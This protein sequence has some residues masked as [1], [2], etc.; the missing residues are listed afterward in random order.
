V[1]DIFDEIHEI[2]IAG[3]GPAGLTAAIY[4]ARANLQPGHG[5]GGGRGGA[6]G[7][8]H[9]CGELPGFPEGILGPDLIAMMKKQ[10]ER[11]GTRVLTDH[12]VSC[13]LSKRPFTVSLRTARHLKAQ[14][15]IVSTGASAS[16]LGLESE[17][18]LKGH[19][20]TACATCDG[21]FFKG[22]EV[23]VIGGGDTAMEEATFLTKFCSKVTVIH[24]RDELRAS[25]IMQERAFEESE[26]RVQMEFRG[27]RS[28][29]RLA[30]QSNGPETARYAERFRLEDFACEGLFLAIGH[31]PNTGSWTG[32]SRP[33]SGFI[34]V[35]I[36]IDTNIG[37]R[38]LRLWGCHG[39]DLQAGDDRGGY[40]MPS[41]H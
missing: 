11:F 31:D 9:G 22:K 4:A 5:R 34:V 27:R 38:S 41:G 13:D 10:A 30:E 26:N 21:F 2:L 32:R 14:T 40:G 25:K 36:T 37:P 12:I 39:P 8:H 33:T 23:A 28:L 29:R 6:A 1:A 15:L 19:G 3:S 7:R 18:R 17:T 24:R 16:W 35:N 20:V